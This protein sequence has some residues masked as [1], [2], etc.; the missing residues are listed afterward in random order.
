ML[1][2]VLDAMGGD[3][4]P[5]EIVKG[6]IAA[7]G[8]N[9]AVLLVGR[10]Q[11]VSRCLA[12]QG[13]KGS[14]IS[15][16][17]AP[18]VISFD[19]PPFR[20]VKAKPRSSIALGMQLVSRGEGGA[21]VSAGSTGAV[22]SAALLHLGKAPGVERPALSIVYQ[23]RNGPAIFLDVGANVDCRPNFLLQ[24]AQLGHTYMQRVMG[25][26]RP[27]VG[28]LNNGEE[29]GKGNQLM[30]ESHCLLRKS[31]LN[32]VGNLE[33][34]DLFRGAA[35]VVV[36]D[37]FTGNMVLKANEGFGETLFAHLTQA[38]TSRFSYRLA[39]WWLRPA[40]VSLKKSLDYSEYGGAPLLGVK[41]NV[42]IAH[43]RSR[44]RAILNALR[45]AHRTAQQGLAET[46]MEVSDDQ[47]RSDH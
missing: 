38:V 6:A 7:S 20:A 13:Y 41:G 29:E 47:T 23:T 25:M 32:F 42:I 43:G 10:E 14:L 40:M 30:R 45:L 16:H 1:P 4:A 35:D 19:E 33:A 9:V 11:E 24:F 26:E 18:E 17:D 21:F 36:T 39:A 15:V 28:L 44:A 8:E 2:I 22:V 5:D 31:T 46:F 27:R 34:R 3:Y 37:G 12:A